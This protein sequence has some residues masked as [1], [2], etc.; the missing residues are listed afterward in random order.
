M[1]NF[2]S[3]FKHVRRERCRSLFSQKDNSLAIVWQHMRAIGRQRVLLAMLIQSA[4]IYTFSAGKDLSVLCMFTSLCTPL[5]PPLYPLPGCSWNCKLGYTNGIHLYIPVHTK[6]FS[7]ATTYVKSS[8]SSC[9]RKSSV[10]F[11][12]HDVHSSTMLSLSDCIMKI[13]CSH[14]YLSCPKILFTLQLGG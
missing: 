7:S 9:A 13:L 3:S 11:F 6:S 4:I 5:I 14:I 2:K 1:K 10:L 8:I 12:Q